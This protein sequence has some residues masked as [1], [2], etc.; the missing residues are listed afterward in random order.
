MKEIKWQFKI[1]AQNKTILP[2]IIILF[3]LTS[4]ISSQLR[5]AEFEFVYK[6]SKYKIR[7]AYCQGNPE[8]CNQLSSDNFIAADLNQ[9][10]IIDEIISGDVSLSEVQEIYDYCLNLLESQNKLSQINKEGKKYIFSDYE[11]NFEIHTLYP[12]TNM[13]LNQFTIADKRKGK[14]YYK[15]SVFMDKDADGTLDE[16]LKGQVG[17]KEA[18]AMYERIIEIGLSKDKLEQINN[19]I[20]VR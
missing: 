4:C 16:L 20:L 8:S 18:Q 2:I 13:P 12:K 7:S 14:V 9:D 15:I 10:R 6:N 5:V 19:N 11:F 1:S 3:I 17:F